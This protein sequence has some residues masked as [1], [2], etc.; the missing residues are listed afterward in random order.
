MTPAAPRRRQLSRF[1]RVPLPTTVSWGRENCGDLRGSGGSAELQQLLRT[2]SEFPFA[3]SRRRQATA[4]LLTPLASVPGARD[5]LGRVPG[6]LAPV[7]SPPAPRETQSW[8]PADCAISGRLAAVGGQGRDE[9][10]D[11]NAEMGPEGSFSAA[12]R[13][14]VPSPASG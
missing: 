8:L 11:V 3:A 6:T 7:H 1:L 12:R 5:L 13:P 9:T 2:A 4:F 14:H 10:L